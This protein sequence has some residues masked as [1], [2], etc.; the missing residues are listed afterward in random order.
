MFVRDVTVAGPGVQGLVYCM[1][2]LRHGRVLG[3]NPPAVVIGRIL[4]LEA[5]SEAEGIVQSCA[6][7]AH[8]AVMAQVTDVVSAHLKEASVD[9][10]VSEV[11]RRAQGPDKGEQSA[12]THERRQH[13]GYPFVEIDVENHSLRFKDSQ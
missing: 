3:V 5:F 6:Q 13:Q 7:I 9:A 10:L 11:Q 4:N 12:P 2:L 8:L 1:K